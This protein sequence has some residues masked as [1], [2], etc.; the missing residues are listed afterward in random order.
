V[1]KAQ[2][3]KWASGLVSFDIIDKKSEAVYAYG[4]ELL[5]SGFITTLAMGVISIIFRQPLAWILFLASFIPLRTTAGGYHA[6]SHAKCFAITIASFTALLTLSQIQFDLA[7]VILPLATFS[8]VLIIL[9]SPVEAVNKELNEDRRQRNR[10]IS[11]CIG[12][13]NFLIATAATFYLQNYLHF[14]AIYFA[15]VFASALSMLVVKVKT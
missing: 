10:K 11:I 13:T 7:N 5:I 14:F 6:S 2:A 9:F 12:T 15:G 4:L 3:T 1:I 8:F